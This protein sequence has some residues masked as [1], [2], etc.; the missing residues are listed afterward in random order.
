[1]ARKSRVS[2]PEARDKQ[3]VFR[4]GI[5]CRL[6]SADGDDPEQ[7]SIENQYKIAER[8]IA[9]HP[10]VRTAGRYADVGVSGMRF[11]RPDFRR[12]EEDLL[13]GRI[14]CIVVKDLSRLG[15]HFSRTAE[16][17]ERRF[18]ALGIRLVCVSEGYDSAAPGA[19]AASFLLPFR[20]VLNESYVRDIS[21][22]IRSGISARMQSGEFLPASGCVPYGYLRSPETGN[23]TVDPQAAPVVL[24]IFTL[25]REGLCI[26]AVADRLNAEGIPSPGRL[27]FLRG[28]T[29]YSRFGQAVWGPGTVRKILRDRVYL[30]ERIHN[31]FGSDRPGGR[32]TRR[33]EQ[34]WQVIPNAH[35]PIMPEELFNAV[36]VPEGEKSIRQTRAPTE[37]DRGLFR[38][39]VFCGDCGSELR[40]VKSCSRPGSDTPSRLY[41]ECGTYLSSRR[42]ICS[43]HDVR[44]D[45]VRA[46]VAGLIERQME[47]LDAAGIPSSG[48]AALTREAAERRAATEKAEAGLERLVTDRIAGILGQE[49]YEYMRAE[50][51]AR[52]SDARMHEETALR[53]LDAWEQARRTEEQRLEALRRYRSLPHI[54]RELVEALVDRVEVLPGRRIRIQLRCADPFANVLPLPNGK[55][56]P[57]DGPEQG[58]AEVH[59]G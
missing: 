49:E 1:M 56:L 30:G 31:R 46:A 21:R 3:V 23:Y 35:P 45:A 57:K 27:R 29:A 55:C 40:P 39:R 54:D 17:V 10:E 15:R 8:W 26:S 53:K 11:D 41:L 13:A 19:D 25:R 4:A 37:E 42:K 43:C 47:L 14:N 12:M 38:G 9:E 16:Y 34:D 50:Y 7:N 28:L 18:P 59:A 20:M 24:Q 44:Q 32:K 58:E 51:A 5:Y 22:K 36:Q 33:N 6:S 2:L 48:R 52:L